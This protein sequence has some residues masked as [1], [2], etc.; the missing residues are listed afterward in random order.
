M[1]LSVANV[2]WCW[3]WIMCPEHWWGDTD[4]GTEVVE[5]WRH[6]LKIS[7]I[8]ESAHMDGSICVGAGTGPW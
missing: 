6:F 4:R 3:C 1:L 2:E 5:L 7:G 8:F